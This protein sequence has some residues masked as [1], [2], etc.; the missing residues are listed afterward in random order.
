MSKFLVYFVRWIFWNILSKAFIQVYLKRTYNYKLTGKSRH[1]PKPPFVVVANHG[2]FFDPWIIGGYSMHP[3]AIMINDDGFRGKG[4]SQW[5]LRQI[6][7]IPK[8]KGASDFKAMKTS[9]QR[10]RERYPVCIFPEGQTSWDGE[11][12]LLYKGLEKIVKKMQC[13]LV[14]Y[15]LQGNFLTKPWWAH[16]IRKGRILISMKVVQPS[17]YKQL[18]S[19][20]LFDLIKSSIYQNEIKDQS[21][22]EY[23]FKGNNLAEGLERF[24]WICMHCGSEDTISTKGSTISCSS[25]GKSWTI[26]AHCR[27]HT[28]DKE[29]KCLEDLKEWSDLHK[30]N[31]HK[32]ITS[33]VAPLAESARVILQQENEQKIFTNT[34]SGKACLTSDTLTFES[35]KGVRSWPVSEIEDYVI[36]KKDLFEF[37]HKERQFRFLFDKKSPMKWVYYLRYLKGYDDC[38]KRGYL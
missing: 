15:K 10:L 4:V 8:R 17:D 5:Y 18:S 6:G 30:A 2:T 37:R 26:D 14:I 36:Q 32:K 28:N 38:E 3:F 29:T 1:L 13:P 34:S 27:L 20:E 19:D 23:P 24:V 33:S 22:L 16:T 7:T 21:N 12:Q 25:C 11:T 35:P 31:V 9:M